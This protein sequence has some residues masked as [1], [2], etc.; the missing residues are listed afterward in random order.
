MSEGKG[1]GKWRLGDE[2][3]DFELCKVPW[4]WRGVLEVESL[5]GSYNGMG[6][7]VEVWGT[8]PH[9]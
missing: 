1:K 4:E 2:P 7:V 5:Y 9:E 8:W 6:R 3:L